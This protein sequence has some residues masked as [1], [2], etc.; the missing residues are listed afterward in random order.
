MTDDDLHNHLNNDDTSRKIM[1]RAAH[2]KVPFTI[3]KEEALKKLKAKM[4][5]HTGS[6]DISRHQIKRIY[7]IVAVAALLLLLFGIWEFLNNPL[8]NVVA[9]KGQHTEYKLPDGSMVAMNAE[10]KISFKKNYFNKSRTVNM[11]GEAFFDVRKGTVFT[12][13][14]KLADIK[15]LGTSFNLVSRDN[16][17]KVSCITGKIQV[18]SG[19][20]SLT[21]TPGESATL[22]NNV[23]LKYSDKN[24][25]N[26]PN[27]RLGESYFENSPLNSVF[28]EIERQFNVNFVVTKMDEKYFTGS[29]TNKNLVNALDIVCIPMGLTYEIGSNSKIF[30][31]EKPQ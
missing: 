2:Y 3:S 1:S 27:W 6:I 23:L 15:I 18:S 16:T 30:I 20:Q 11:E 9:E 5:H 24:I 31:R 25:K 10:S 7:S 21:I 26:I 28:K 19:S 14:T 29:F 12:I 8:V 13:N 17:F 4:E 22:K